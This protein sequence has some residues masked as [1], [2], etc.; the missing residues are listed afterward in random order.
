MQIKKEELD[1]S[2]L[3]ID[4]VVKYIE[5]NLQEN[6]ELD[7][8][9][10]KAGYSKF[11]LLRVFSDKVGCTIHQYIIRRRITEAAKKLVYS[12]KVIIDIANES[13]YDS[14]QSFTQ[15]FKKLYYMTP[16]MYRT[17][18]VFYPI[19]LCY[20]KQEVSSDKYDSNCEMIAS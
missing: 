11:H 3:V 7:L 16:N 10:A 8:I 9:A 1:N 2:S 19:Q 5:N 15:S 17:K 20:L 6:L 4:G 13:G 18:A 14:Q 12:N